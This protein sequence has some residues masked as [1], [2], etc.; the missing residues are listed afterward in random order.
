MAA[1]KGGVPVGLALGVEHSSRA[2]TSPQA[3][4][5]LAEQ[6]GLDELVLGIAVLISALTIFGPLCG[7]CVVA[8]SWAKAQRAR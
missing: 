1:E 6:T 5:Y 4:E 7:A 2:R 3:S 8:C